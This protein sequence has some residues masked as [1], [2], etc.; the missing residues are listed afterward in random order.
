MFKP[1]IKI[2][3]PKGLRMVT[4]WQPDQTLIFVVAGSDAI[5]CTLQYTKINKM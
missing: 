5:Y 2:V 4:V 3:L 1:A